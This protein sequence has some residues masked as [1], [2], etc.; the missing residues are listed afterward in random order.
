MRVATIDMQ[1]VMQSKLHNRVELPETGI[2]VVTGENGAG[3][4]TLLEAVSSA[5]WGQT[6][7]GTSLWSD[8]P[9]TKQQMVIVKTYDGDVLT[10]TAKPTVESRTLR[11]QLYETQMK[12]LAACVSA[13]GSHDAWRRT[14]VFSSDGATKFTSATDSERKEFL[15]TI[16]GLDRFDEAFELA[17][18]E[19]KRWV[20]RHGLAM[21]EVD[22]IKNGIEVVRARLDE[23]SSLSAST[24]GVEPAEPTKLIKKRA[25]LKAQRE[26]IQ[27]KLEGLAS[28]RGE[29]E[30]RAKEAARKRRR[31]EAGTCPTCGQ[32]IPEATRSHADAECEEAERDA[33][34]LA[35]QTASIHATLREQNA[36]LN[37]KIQDL[38]EKID[39]AK[40]AARAYAEQ[41]KLLE[42]LNTSASKYRS[43]ALDLVDTLEEASGKLDDVEKSLRVSEAVRKVLSLNG[44]RA[45]MLVRALDTVTQIANLWLAR[46]ASRDLR[47]VLK[48]YTEKARGGVREAIALHIEGAGGGRG[49]A[50]AS[51]GERRR[52]DIAL[53]L[54][55]AE[56]S[57]STS[58]G[59]GTLFMDE[60]FDALD[61]EGIQAVS[62]VLKKIAADRCVVVIT[63]NERLL[64]DLRSAG[65]VML[66][67]V[68]RNEG[69][70]TVVV[71]R[72]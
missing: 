25:T 45:F 28:V 41:A 51:G 3:K 9:E 71:A 6:L 69:A 13:F 57:G 15:E 12:Q 42:T 48:P 22:R 1:G 52:I 23:L 56:L 66:L 47:L 20:Q 2:V 44:V 14:H 39:E 67:R 62:R 55:L 30:E 11:G 31:L 19:Q 16:L 33:Q 54:A 70:G 21:G 43:E 64:E 38:R 35:K 34:D 72:V 65:P 32:A 50:G 63:H 37:E 10:R 4:S 24:Q 29:A 36:E 61:R 60:V 68:T 7:R 26:E 53:L 58:N 46:L 27:A 8:E 40:G 18:A 59:R 17:T 5:G 49:Y